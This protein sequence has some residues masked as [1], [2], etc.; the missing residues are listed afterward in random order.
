[1]GKT[2]LI[3]SFVRKGRA[4]RDAAS[5]GDGEVDSSTFLIHDMS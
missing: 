4:L 3:L 5:N 2:K 1:M